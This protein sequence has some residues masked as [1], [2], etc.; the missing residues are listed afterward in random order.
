MQF[1][2]D[3]TKDQRNQQKHGVSFKEAATVFDDELQVTIRDPD[4]SLGEHRYV[5][6][7]LSVEGRL[8]V[9]SHTEDDDDR[10]R[11]ISARSTTAT[12]RRI[13]EEGE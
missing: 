12:E 3:P 13:Y 2:W 1:E 9:V 8:V 10:I 7:G 11:V 6:I 5:T 4:H